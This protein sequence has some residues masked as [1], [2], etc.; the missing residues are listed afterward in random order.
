[1]RARQL[2]VPAVHASLIARDGRPDEALSLFRMA[3][4]LDLDDLTGTTARGVHPATAGGVWQALVYGFLGIRPE[5]T[6][7]RVDP[8]IPTA[9]TEL[10]IHLQHRARRLEVRASPDALHIR[11]DRPALV[12]VPGAGTSQVTSAGA[13]WRRGPS[14]WERSAE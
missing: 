9:W 7:L 2:A 13:I 5:G 10:R 8:Q 1:M 11:S 4:R 3:C 12:D 14:G 6:A